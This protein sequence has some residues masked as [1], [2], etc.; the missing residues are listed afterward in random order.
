[1]AGTVLK[2]NYRIQVNKYN[3]YEVVDII[4]EKMTYNMSV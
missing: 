3:Y 1:M 4:M 2:N